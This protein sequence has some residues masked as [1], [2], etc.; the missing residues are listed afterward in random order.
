MGWRRY[1]PLLQTIK[2]RDA[3]RPERVASALRVCR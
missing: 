2:R 1:I 3:G